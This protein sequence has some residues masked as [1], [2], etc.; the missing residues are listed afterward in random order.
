LPLKHCQT[1]PSLATSLLG[2]NDVLLK[3]SLDSDKKLPFDVR[4]DVTV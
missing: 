4:V 2:N 3:L 1:S